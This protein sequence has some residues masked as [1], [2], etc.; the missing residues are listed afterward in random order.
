MTHGQGLQLNPWAVESIVIHR[1]RGHRSTALNKLTYEWHQQLADY[2]PTPLRRLTRLEMELGLERV[3]V[4]DETSRFGLH[5]FKILGASW[6][7]HKILERHGSSISVLVTATDGNHGQAVAR[8]AR[9]AGL[10]SRIFVPTSISRARMR[11]L[12]GE[13]AFVEVVRGDYDRAVRRAAQFVSQMPEQRK[14]VSDIGMAGNPPDAPELVIEGYSTMFFELAEQLA[15]VETPILGLVFVQIGV[16][17]LA[18]A[19][20]RMAGSFPEWGGVHLMGV[21]PSTA[22]CA[23]RS[24]V[25]GRRVR[26]PRQSAHTVMSGLDTSILSPAAWRDIAGRFDCFIAIGD[27][28]CERAVEELQA[29]GIDADASGAAG[30]AGLLASV[31]GPSSAVRELLTR[32]GN[33]LVIATGSGPASSVGQR[34]P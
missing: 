30:V 8:L 6:A 19:A 13:G 12:H 3:W 20:A 17:G 4:K 2:E 9:E 1:K 5:S 31:S 21:E 32:S 18:A 29:A 7:V 25:A 34:C 27:N 11:A 26:F 23:M 22:A 33:V 14:L 16:G 10:E 28:W 15:A 24:A